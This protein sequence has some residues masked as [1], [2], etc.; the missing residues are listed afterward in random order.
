MLHLL[1]LPEHSLLLWIYAGL[2]IVTFGMLSVLVA[3][4]GRHVRPGFGPKIKAL[5]GWI[6]MEVGALLMMPI[7]LILESKGMTTSV[8]LLSSIW[9]AHYLNRSFIYPIRY[10]N[11]LRS[12]PII[13]PASGFLFGV[14]NGYVNAIGLTH[15]TAHYG[16]TWIFEPQFL[17][18]II[19]CVIG[20]V[21]NNHSDIALFRLRRRCGPGYHLPNEGLHRL[22]AAPNYL[23]EIIEWLGWAIASWNPAALLFVAYSVANLV[24]RAQAHLTWYRSKFSDYPSNR[25]ALVPFLW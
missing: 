20:A 5:H 14:F 7:A 16:E 17:A 18:G 23:G 24:P 10:W 3:P 4:Y 21:I 25:K 9:C 15:V 1:T 12:M 19:I 13:I 6:I 11:D 8:I 2:T 22:V